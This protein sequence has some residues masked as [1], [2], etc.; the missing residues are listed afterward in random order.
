MAALSTIQQSAHTYFLIR[1]VYFKLYLTIGETTSIQLKM[2]VIFT[3]QSPILVSCFYL[4]YLFQGAKTPYLSY[5]DPSTVMGLREYNA[6]L[7][8]ITKAAAFM[9]TYLLNNTVNANVDMTAKSKLWEKEL[10]STLLE[11]NKTTQYMS[12]DFQAERSIADILDEKIAADSKYVVISYVLML[13][14]TVV[15]LGRLDTVE[16]KMVVGFLAVCLEIL[17]IVIAL[18]ITSAGNV[19]LSPITL[20]VIPFL[21]LGT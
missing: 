3:V 18:G 13:V 20:Q 14:Y 21:I 9:N 5:I 10:I 8:N 19:P 16:S 1:P 17:A 15:A 4:R 12:I 2:M 11:F 6:K 7:T